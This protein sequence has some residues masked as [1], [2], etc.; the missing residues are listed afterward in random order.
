MTPPCYHCPHR[1]LW[2]HVTCKEYLEWCRLNAEALERRRE[3]GA[4]QG[5]FW[6]SVRM[7]LEQERRGKRRSRQRKQRER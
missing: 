3:Y 7:Q 6:D 1:H 2:C 4:A 5:V